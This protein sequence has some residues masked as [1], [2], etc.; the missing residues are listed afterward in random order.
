M[1]LFQLSLSLAFAK[2][3]ARMTTTLGFFFDALRFWVELVIYVSDYLIYIQ[4][5]ISQALVIAWKPVSW[6]IARFNT[7]FTPES[8]VWYDSMCLERF[9]LLVRGNLPCFGQQCSNA[10]L[11]GRENSFVTL[12]EL[13][14]WSHSVSYRRQVCVL[15]ITWTDVLVLVLL[16]ACAVFLAYVSFRIFCESLRIVDPIG[17]VWSSHYISWL[18]SRTEQPPVDSRTVRSVFVKCDVIEPR[19]A[20]N[21]T[22][23]D[24]AAVRNASV[25]TIELVCAKLGMTP[26]FVQTAPADVKNGR[27]G[28]RSYYWG[29]DLSVQAEAF[30]P[31]ERSA[32]AIVDVDMYMD[33]PFLLANHVSVYLLSTFQPTAASCGE[34]EYSFTFDENNEVTYTVSG[35]AVY[36]HPVWN[37]GSDIYTVTARVWYGLGVRTTVYNVDRRQTDAHHQIVLFTPMRTFVSPLL[38]ISWLLGGSF[39]KR[40]DVYRDGFIRLLVKKPNN[41]AV[42][43]SKAGNLACAT[44]DVRC[45]DTLATTSRIGKTDM[46]VAGVRQILPDIG[47]E[48]A[49]ILVEY[50]RR[51]VTYSLDTVFPVQESVQQYQFDPAQYDPE[52]ALGTVPYMSPII[53]DCFAPVKHKSNDEACVQGRIIDVEPDE[54]EINHFDLLLMKDFVRELVPDALAGTGVPVSVEEVYERQNRP[55]QRRILDVASMCAKLTVDEPVQC[56]QKA[57]SYGDIKDPRN[58]STIPGVNKLNYSSYMYSFTDTVLKRQFWYAFAMTPLD[59]AIRVMTICYTALFCY[60]T[61]LS[62]FD[63]RVSNVLRTL[64]DM[65]MMRWVHKDHQAELAELMATQFQQK[66]RTRHGVKFSTGFSRLS[67]SP[68]TSPFN[69]IDNAFMAYKALRSTAK[70]GVRLT[71]AQAWAGLGIYGGDDGL[72]ADVDPKAYVKSCASVGQKLEIVESPRGS[73]SVTFLSRLYSPMVW[74]GSLDS[75][76]DV[77][78]QLAKIHVS[79]GMAPDVTP[80]MKLHEKM[81]G[82]YLTDCDTPII[83]PLARLVVDKF[84]ESS[85][86]LGVKNYFALFPGHVQYPNAD[87]GGWMVA[88]VNELLPFFDH[89]LFQSWL[90]KVRFGFADVLQPPMCHPGKFDVPDVKRPVV[91]NG[92]VLL[93]KPKKSVAFSENV[94]EHEIPASTDTPPED[95]SDTPVVTGEVGVP[96]VGPSV[97]SNYALCKHI[98]LGQCKHGDR[99]NHVVKG[100]KCYG[101]R[102]KYEHGAEMCKYAKRDC[103]TKD[104]QR[105]HKDNP[106]NKNVP[107]PRLV[108]VETNPGPGS[109]DTCH[110]GPKRGC[111]GTVC[112]YCLRIRGGYYDSCPDYDSDHWG[113]N[114]LSTLAYLSVEKLDERA[115]RYGVSILPW[116]SV[117]MVGSYLEAPMKFNF[118]TD[119]IVLSLY[120]RMSTQARRDGNR[121]E[122]IVRLGKYAAGGVLAAAGN[123]VV[124]KSAAKAERAI[125]RAIKK[126]RNNPKSMGSVSTASAPVTM[127]NIIRSVK[128]SVNRSSAGVRVRNRELLQSSV[129]GSVGFQVQTIASV[130]PGL[131]LTFPWLSIQ[132]GQYEQYAF[133]YLKF[134]YYPSTNT[135][136]SGDVMLMI[137]Y[138]AADNVPVSETQLLDHED[139]VIAPVWEAVEMVCDVS[140]MRALGPR[141]FIRSVAMAGDI[142]TFDVGTFYLGT[143]NCASALSVGKLFVEYDVEFFVPQL[144]PNNDLSPTQTSWWVNPATQVLISGAV[145]PIISQVAVQSLG[146]MTLPM[147]GLN[148]AKNYNPTT[149]TWFPPAGVYT[150]AISFAYNSNSNAR[151]LVNSFCQKNFNALLNTSGLGEALQQNVSGGGGQVGTISYSVVVSCNGT[152]GIQFM[153]TLTDPTPSIVLE[154]PFNSVSIVWRLG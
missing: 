133:R 125:E 24:S 39:L 70:H 69:T 35:G 51:K 62:R 14:K 5:L 121:I 65:Y 58:I 11:Y 41:T 144:T 60:N 36:K 138:D 38:D 3:F 10:P 119:S 151:L 130:N 32:I 149:G 16:A 12:N 33:M 141:K 110:C 109:L 131:P 135:S 13:S 52:A 128:P 26:Y 17:R 56:F 15:Y 76:C 126:P 78:R 45:D 102:C 103:M 30:D 25:T 21:H 54:K 83:G 29:K 80:F 148:L 47:P 22:H 101:A 150:I 6:E 134:I 8:I 136:S 111:P 81:S 117:H 147:D 7:I 53:N 4:R 64:E 23:P 40:L 61:D 95:P 19:P 120:Q 140:Q 44:I 97:P 86:T 105:V 115:K 99:C 116:S 27:A 1:K 42:S 89:G 98:V 108:G 20:L 57:E 50:H 96:P 77:P 123:Y 85:T 34:G 143:N 9:A 82:F 74:Y 90:E 94:T 67:G 113:C 93:P 107:A 129:G 106:S 59:I 31:P 84:G 114:N 43:T 146:G 139:A 124:G 100:Q 37:Y 75:M 91:V 145:T 46:T 18:M 73:D 49:A 142:K 132:A 72:T 28:S 118:L 88:K 154:I 92:E 137:D 63:G 2:A 48:E 55:T 79:A 127:G 71:H 152:D 68:E 153:V 112:P 87:E 122:K 66:A 104:C